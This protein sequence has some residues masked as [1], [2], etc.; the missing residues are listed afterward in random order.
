METCQ[1]IEDWMKKMGY[2]G[3][4][5]TSLKPFCNPATQFIWQQ[6]ID[7]VKPKQE[8][9][10]MRRNI[11]INR[12][13]EQ[14]DSILM[15]LDESFVKLPVEE[16]EIW[17]KKKELQSKLEEVE[18]QIEVKET[19]IIE[20][21]LQN[22]MKYV[23]LQG[24]R[25]T[26]K[27]I[28]EKTFLYNEKS[29]HLKKDIAKAEEMLNLIKNL[30]P[31]E[32]TEFTNREAVSQTLHEC[33]K[34]LK[35]YIEKKSFTVSSTLSNTFLVSKPFE[36]FATPRNSKFSSFTT[37]LPPLTISQSVLRNYNATTRK[38][39][40]CSRSFEDKL[41]DIN[42]KCYSSTLDLCKESNFDSTIKKLL[43][44]N[45][46]IL[47]FNLLR[48]IDKKHQ[49]QLLDLISKTDELSGKPEIY[50]EEL[51]LVKLRAKYVEYELM[52]TKSNIICSKIREEVKRVQ[53]QNF[54]T[55]TNQYKMPNQVSR[56]QIF[57][58]LEQK[59]SGLDAA[60]LL[61]DKK[62]KELK[63]ET[64]NSDDIIFVQQ[65]LK[66]VEKALDCAVENL[67]NKLSIFNENCITL[68]KTRN[69]TCSL[70][71]QQQQFTA[72]VDWAAPLSSYLISKEIEVFADFPLEFNRHT[73]INGEKAP[74]RN[75]MLDLPYSKDWDSNTLRIVASAVDY[76]YS[77]P[78]LC[79][80]KAVQD[81]ISAEMFKQ[82]EKPFKYLEINNYGTEDLINKEKYISTILAQC[83]SIMFSESTRKILNF[84][85]SLEETVNHWM[86]MPFKNYISPSLLLE[87]Q[88]YEYYENQFNDLYKHL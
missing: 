72:D 32:S 59:D 83:N 58:K 50:N 47:V 64:D 9:E 68:A 26:N 81:K 21:N 85:F 3:E 54:Q 24:I 57:F 51:H 28:E 61:A 6:I 2:D 44:N 76:P 70:A 53:S 63:Q 65:K 16:I 42:G 86:N 67:K 31:V 7:K 5:P 46:R 77:P 15:Q 23:N 25:K 49:Q 62:L 13:K 8:I 29:A 37:P 22:K 1:N 84:P 69:E 34:K 41:P 10:F 48:D 27:E 78:E 30:T 36:I 38:D 73:I 55:L 56:L 40:P 80:V 60:L 35:E 88:P 20:I 45:N 33:A 17:K 14:E 87:G 66:N 79:L 43:T 71:K 39:G 75:V 19:Q 74:L 82:L 11:I 12:L 52:C 4:M 18:K